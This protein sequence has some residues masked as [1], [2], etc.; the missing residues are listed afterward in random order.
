MVQLT[1]TECSI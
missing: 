1:V